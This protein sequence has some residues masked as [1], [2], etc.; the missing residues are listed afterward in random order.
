M[1][2]KQGPQKRV[3]SIASIFQR[4]QSIYPSSPS[5]EGSHRRIKQAMTLE[6]SKHRAQSLIGASL[7]LAS[8]PTKLITKSFGAKSRRQKSPSARK[9]KGR[10][11]LTCEEP[12]AEKFLRAKSLRQQNRTRRYLNK[13]LVCED[14]KLHRRHVKIHRPHKPS[15]GGWRFKEP[16]YARMRHR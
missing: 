12:K 2:Y 3:S 6:R 9:A 15:E 4:R 7:P 5:E 14:L 8:L 11:V 16:E 13:N 10:K 1:I